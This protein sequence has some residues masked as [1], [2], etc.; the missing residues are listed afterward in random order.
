MRG[1]TIVFLMSAAVGITA[2]FVATP[3]ASAQG[4]GVYC[5]CESCAL[6]S[7]AEGHVDRCCNNTDLTNLPSYVTS[8]NRVCGSISIGS[9]AIVGGCVVDPRSGLQGTFCI[10]GE[11]AFD[12]GTPCDTTSLARTCAA[13]ECANQSGCIPGTCL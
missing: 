11:D 2:M 10:D 9:Q 3:K 5:Q 6:P 12:P 13:C 7:G 8:P 1:L 4:V